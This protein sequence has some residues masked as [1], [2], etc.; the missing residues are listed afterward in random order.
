MSGLKAQGK[1]YT[2]YLIK[3]AIQN[4][5]MDIKDPMNV[6]FIQVSK[7]WNYLEKS[8]S[9]LNFNLSYDLEVGNG[10]GVYLRDLDETSRLN[11]F[12]VN[13]QPK[14]VKMDDPA[15]NASKLQMEARL[16]LEPTHAWINTPENVHLNNGGRGF[17]FQVD[18]TRLEPGFHFGQI[19]AYDANARNL[20]PLFSVPI[21]ITKPDPI[22]IHRQT[23]AEAPSYIKYSDLTFGPGEILRRFVS[24]PAGANYAGMTMVLDMFYT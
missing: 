6:K 2:P 18:P 12:V 24:V 15:Q 11:S 5:G 4:S 1:S 3:R 23:G 16:C 8:L 17:G 21:T 19:H 7:A 14:F 9:A 22:H 10:R 13:V 20:G